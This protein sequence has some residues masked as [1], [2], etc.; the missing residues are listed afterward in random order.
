LG[1]D[2]GAHLSD[3][4][5]DQGELPEEDAHESGGEPDVYATSS[6]DNDYSDEQEQEESNAAPA[7][8][9]YP[10]RCAAQ[11][12]LGLAFEKLHLTA[13]ARHTIIMTIL[14]EGFDIEELRMCYSHEAMAKHLKAAE[15]TLFSRTTE[16]AIVGKLARRKKTV[17]G[18]DGST[19][20]VPAKAHQQQVHSIE[21]AVRRY[22]TNPY[23]RQFLR[24]GTDGVADNV[25]VTQFNQTPLW[26]E[27]RK[28]S[29]LL[30]FRHAGTEYC[31]GDYVEV[32]VLRCVEAC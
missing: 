13:N 31:I 27:W 23:L 25:P 9:Y 10:Y 8:K 5:D 18:S 22:Y 1:V 16:S 14:T 3:Q 7:D 2:D 28:T 24:F 17:V 19:V 4:E 21:D 20:R 15:A 26:R 6:D 11:G 29:E 12:L 32:E 30:S